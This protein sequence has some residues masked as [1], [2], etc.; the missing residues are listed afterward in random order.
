M[1]YLR[2]IPRDRTPN[3][4]GMRPT[5]QKPPRPSLTGEPSGCLQISMSSART[6]G[7]DH[8]CRSLRELPALE[9][10]VVTLAAA[11]VH[12]SASHRIWPS[13]CV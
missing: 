2:G 4:H 1:T 7:S 10:S 12:V 9:A 11:N 5:L 3:M 6:V 13:V 8:F